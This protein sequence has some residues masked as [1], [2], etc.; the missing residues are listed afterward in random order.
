MFFS[1]AEVTGI[2][3]LAYFHALKQPKYGIWFSAPINQEMSIQ[4]HGFYHHSCKFF[5]TI[6]SSATTCEFVL[7]INPGQIM[8]KFQKFVFSFQFEES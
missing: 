4:L 1:A 7:K 3:V 6:F 5:I 8:T 2:L